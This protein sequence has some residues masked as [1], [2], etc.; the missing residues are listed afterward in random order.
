MSALGKFIAGQV[1]K[2]ARASAKAGK[3]KYRAYFVD[4]RLYEGCRAEVD[5]ALAEAGVA[6]AIVEG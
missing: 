6:R 1:I 2:Q 5:A 4:L 3:A